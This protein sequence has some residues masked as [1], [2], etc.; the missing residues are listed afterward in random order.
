MKREYL[1]LFLILFGAIFVRFYRFSSPIADWHSWRQADTSSV[2][3]NFVKSGFDLLHPRFDD[4]SNVPSGK[5][6]PQGYRFVEFPLYN[7]LQ[8]STA[9]LVPTLPIE[10]SGRV[11][12]ILMSV[13]SAVFLFL[14]TRKYAGPRTAL[15]AAFFY[16]FLPYSIYYGRVILP[17]PMMV[18]ATLGG[19]YFFDKWLEKST[20]GKRTLFYLLA[21]VCTASALLLKPFALFFMLPMVF[22]AFDHF[23]LGV[24]KRW[25]LWLFAVLVVAPLLL[26]RTWMAQYPEGIPVND[27]LFNG[28]NIRF[29]GAFF[30]WIFADRLGRLILGYWGVGIFLIGVLVASAQVVVHTKKAQFFF[31]S[32]LLSCLLYVIVIARGNVQHDYYQLPLLPS[33][34]LF[35]GIGSAF[36]LNTPKDVAQKLFGRTVLIVMIVFSFFFG[37]YVVRDYF[38][39]NNRNIVA[40][41]KIVQEKTPADATIIAPYDGDTSFLYQTNRQGW[42]SFE[43]P[44]PEM[45]TMGADYLILVNPTQQDF[46]GFGKM[47]PIVA[48]S[49]EYLLLKLQ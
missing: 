29:K 26:W 23:K 38:N 31:Y 44:L 24:F 48:S 7:V 33:I 39:I 20:S 22:L 37:W 30:Y 28:G 17:D 35:L 13:L 19:I 45:I 1:F 47:F 4:I 36:L 9:L 8:A 42:A 46:D 15:F 2:S 6:N 10:Q 14:L 49:P 12:T 27:W 21:V 5:D 41:G 3:R 25:E 11:V 32:F 34:A 16:A 40:A 18:T 43:K